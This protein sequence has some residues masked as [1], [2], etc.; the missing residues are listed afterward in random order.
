[1]LLCATIYHRTTVLYGIVC[2]AFFPFIC[3]PRYDKF[4]IS[5][6]KNESY[7]LPIAPLFPMD[8][9]HKKLKQ[10]LNDKGQTLGNLL[11]GRNCFKRKGKKLLNLRAC[12]CVYRHI[13]LFRY[14]ASQP[15]DNACIYACLRSHAVPACVRAYSPRV[16]RH[17]VL[18]GAGKSRGRLYANFY[19]TDFTSRGALVCPY[20]SLS[21]PANPAR[22]FMVCISAIPVLCRYTIRLG[23]GIRPPRRLTLFQVWGFTGAYGARNTICT[24]RASYACECF[25]TSS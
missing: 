24:I 6:N 18:R 4:N 11:G 2:V 5:C 1:M 14:L 22:H 13:P 23:V 12:S 19:T 17:S 7:I 3:L 15:W 16:K 25:T 21:L 20:V 8:G 9:L 10:L